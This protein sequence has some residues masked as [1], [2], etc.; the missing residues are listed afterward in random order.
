LKEFEGNSG[1]SNDNSQ[2][3]SAYL[4]E[5]TSVNADEVLEVLEVLVHEKQIEHGIDKVVNDSSRTANLSST[6]PN[7]TY[8][9]EDI[10][11]FFASDNGQEEEHSLE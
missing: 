1:I 11:K 10:D 4:I 3:N 5:N 8:T 2:N 6:L 9:K 7:Y